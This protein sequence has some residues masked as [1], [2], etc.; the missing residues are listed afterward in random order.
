MQK[1]AK[2]KHK[3]CNP[4]WVHKLFHTK[5]FKYEIAMMNQNISCIS[6]SYGRLH[7]MYL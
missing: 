1:E 5:L 4:L 3:S 2:S 7:K 6:K